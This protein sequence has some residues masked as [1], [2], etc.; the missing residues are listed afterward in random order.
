[1]YRNGCAA[2]NDVS[3]HP[4]KP[5]IISGRLTVIVAREDN[6][7]LSYSKVFNVS[8]GNSNVGAQLS[9]FLILGN[10]KRF[11]THSQLFVFKIGLT[12]GEESR[13]CC[14]YED[15]DFECAFCPVF[16]T[17]LGAT[18][19]FGG[20]WL[21]FFGA[22]HRFWLLGIGGAALIAGWLSVAFADD[23]QSAISS[24]F[25]FNAFS[26]HHL[27]LPNRVGISV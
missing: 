4:G 11:S 14:G 25:S 21:M 27:A 9:S 2:Q 8:R 24:F 1:M 22:R 20:G 5:N 6:R 3:I 7:L 18:L 10:P 17:V 23:V 12:A 26:T 13:D 19:I 16:P 15:S